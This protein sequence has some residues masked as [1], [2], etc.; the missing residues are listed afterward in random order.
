MAIKV[1]TASGIWCS[2][3]SSF[4]QT[5]SREKKCKSGRAASPC[6]SAFRH[7]VIQD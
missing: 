3:T 5:P 7:R 2:H 1:L 4:F 6:R